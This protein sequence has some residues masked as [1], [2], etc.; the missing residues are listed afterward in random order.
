M[1]NHEREQL[2]PREAVEMI[3]REHGD[4]LYRLC[5]L[6]LGNVQ[7]AQ[8]AVQE[9]LIKVFRHW[10]TFR[11]ES[12]V[13]TW[14]VRITVYTCRDL[15]R[16]NWFRKVDRSF[17]ADDVQDRRENE[18]QLSGDVTQAVMQLPEKYRLPVIL[19]YYQ[20][21]AVKDVASILHI[22]LNTALTRL[23]R[24]RDQLRG[25]LTEGGELR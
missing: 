6:Y 17:S 3:V 14:L 1:E 22:P 10:D 15:R 18:T 2:S 24:G 5:C 25:K 8:D 23:K 13:S 9:V 20:G 16:S 12:A 21:L 19:H 4:R 11:Y 7:D